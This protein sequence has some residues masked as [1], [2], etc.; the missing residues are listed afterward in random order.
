MCPAE[1]PIVE[2]EGE[3]GPVILV[4][5]DEVMIRLGVAEHL[6]EAGFMVI[7]AANGQEA[8]AVTEAGVDIDLLFSD[9]DMPA[10]DGIGLAQWMLLNRPDT[11]VVLTSGLASALVTAKTACPHVKAFVNKPYGYEAVTDTLRK[12][13]AQRARR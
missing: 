13:I 11:P 5:E 9:I 6:R 4:A 1:E 8:R 12:I 2:P 3:R 7:E 10:L